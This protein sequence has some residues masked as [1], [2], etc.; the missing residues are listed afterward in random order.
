MH[1]FFLIWESG[2]SVRASLRGSRSR[3]WLDL[4]LVA[5]S[6]SQRYKEAPNAACR[7]DILH[8]VELPLPLNG[9]DAC[10]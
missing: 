3:F 5:V 6:P 1:S 4:D 8:A 10:F 9:V 2:T 7:G